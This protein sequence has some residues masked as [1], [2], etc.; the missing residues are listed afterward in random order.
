[1]AEL[2]CVQKPNSD[3][4]PKQRRAKTGETHNSSTKK[5][6]RS[7][8]HGWS[9]RGTKVTRKKAKRKPDDNYYAVVKGRKPGIYRKWSD[10][11]A[12][13]KDFS[14]AIVRG[15]KRELDAVNYLHTVRNQEYVFARAKECMDDSHNWRKVGRPALR[16]LLNACNTDLTRIKIG[17]ED[18]DRLHAM[19]GSPL[20]PDFEITTDSEVIGVVEE[21]KMSCDRFLQIVYSGKPN[22]P[23]VYHL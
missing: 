7:R 22:L 15:H 16:Q 1:M 8:G 4:Q 3:L 10:V 6:R 14:G 5:R 9:Q 19:V 17:L 11:E 23:E 12:Q 20:A 18:L 13:V 21:L 2:E